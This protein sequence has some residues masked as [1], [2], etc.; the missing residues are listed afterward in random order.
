MKKYILYYNRLVRKY[1][2][3][4]RKLHKAGS[5]PY[6]YNRKDVL[7]KRIKELFKRIQEFKRAFRITVASGAI[8]SS[9]L[10]MTNYAS[11]QQLTLETSSQAGLAHAE[12]YSSPTFT[13]VNGDGNLDIVIGERYGTTQGGLFVFINE[14][15]SFIRLSESNALSNITL[16][17]DS[18]HNNPDFNG[19]GGYFGPD[20]ADYDGDEDEDLFVGQTDGDGSSQVSY[21]RIRFFEN[22]GGTYTEKFGSDNPLSAFSDG[23]FTKPTFVDLN[24]DGD[25]DVVIGKGSGEIVY[26]ENDG[27]GNFAAA[28]ENPFSGFFSGNGSEEGSEIAFADIDGDGDLDGIVGHKDGLI[29]YLENTGTAETTAFEAVDGS[30]NP[31]DGITFDQGDRI[32]PE[33]ADLDA[34]GDLDL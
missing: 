3:Y 16:Q 13:D 15:G 14:N 5:S 10:L 9:M 18:V 6:H 1:N 29:T 32:S 21:E 2:K 28:A 34:D 11:A 27:Q 30:G 4:N 20:F 19:G 8:A 26:W 31:F 23:D 12:N 33:F 24:G 22:E 17:I 25:L 7:V